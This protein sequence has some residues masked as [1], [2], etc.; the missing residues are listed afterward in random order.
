MI[1]FMQ[2]KT[3]DPMKPLADH[4]KAEMIRLRIMIIPPAAAAVAYTLFMFLYGAE[5]C[6][7]VLALVC[8][9]TAMG[10]TTAVIH[11]VG[12]RHPLVYFWYTI[13]MAVPIPLV[14]LLME[15]AGGRWYGRTVAIL[16]LFGVGAIRA[17]FILFDSDSEIVKG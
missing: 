9:C 3:N 7:R 13:A 14:E 5:P 4:E 8:S 11:P 12:F 1:E 10:W 15:P 2:E 16:S 17:Y 6:Y